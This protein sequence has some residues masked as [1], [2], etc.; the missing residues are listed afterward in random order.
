MLKRR[1]LPMTDKE[2]ALEIG[3]QLIAQRKEIT[4]M[5]AVFMNMKDKPFGNPIPW[6][7]Y[8][9]KGM[10]QPQLCQRFDETLQQLRVGIHTAN[11]CSDLLQCLHSGSQT[12]SIVAK[13]E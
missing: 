4:A 13:I 1:I 7:E 9:A 10:E 5:R 11:S 3:Y 6:Q 12:G 2:L 8:V